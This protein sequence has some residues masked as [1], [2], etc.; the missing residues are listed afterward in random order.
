MKIFNIIWSTFLVLNGDEI[1]TSY[2][3]LFPKILDYRFKV[4]KGKFGFGIF[5]KERIQAN[6]LVLKASFEQIIGVEKAFA[7]LDDIV[8]D[9]GQ[10]LNCEETMVL[11]LTLESEI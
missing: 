2:F 5:A 11:F 7:P 1:E 10:K 4:S 3:E 6:D 9:S 8:R